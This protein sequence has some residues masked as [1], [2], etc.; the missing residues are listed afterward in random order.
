MLFENGGQKMFHLFGADRLIKVGH[1][2]INRCR[3][4]GRIGRCRWRWWRVSVGRCLQFVV[5]FHRFGNGEWNVSCS[6]IP[7]GFHCCSGCCQSCSNWGR[8]SCL[9]WWGCY[10]YCFYCC[11]CYC[12]CRVLYSIG[13]AFFAKTI[14]V[15]SNCKAYPKCKLF[16]PSNQIDT[17]IRFQ[18]NELSPSSSRMKLAD[19]TSLLII[20]LFQGSTTS[21]KI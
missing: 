7:F 15:S 17:A 5:G 16:T 19:V 3:R 8:W 1:V 21:Q 10:H 9:W 14:C 13:I 4:I 6:I 2:Q 18:F 11:R 12:C 20:F